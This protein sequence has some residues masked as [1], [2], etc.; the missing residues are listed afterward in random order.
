MKRYTGKFIAFDEKGC[1]YTLYIYTEFI[2]DLSFENMEARIEKSKEIRTSDGF[3]VNRLHKGEYKIVD[4]DIVLR[5][6]S[7]DAP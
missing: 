1:E 7:P 5:S 3:Y 2:N 4:L 6:D